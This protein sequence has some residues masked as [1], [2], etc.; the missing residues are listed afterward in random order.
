MLNTYPVRAPQSAHPDAREL[1]EG[2]QVVHK[3]CEEVVVGHTDI[4]CHCGISY[5]KTHKPT[6]SDGGALPFVAPS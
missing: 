4:N 1:V 6:C 2:Y 3:L 5:R